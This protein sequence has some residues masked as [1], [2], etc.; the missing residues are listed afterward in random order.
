MKKFLF[1]LFLFF[2]PLNVCANKKENVDL[3]KC[4]DG[5]TSIV[6]D[7][8]NEIKIR[9]LAIDT[10]ETKHPTKGEEKYGK[11]ASE[12]TCN[13]LTNANKIQIEYD[14]NSDKK[15]KYDRYLVWVYVDDV[16]LQKSLVKNGLAKVAYLYGD[17]KY[18]DELKELEKE[19]KNA[20]IGIWE[21]YS[22]DNISTLQIILI[23]I[24]AII[25]ISYFLLNK[26][27]RNKTIKN[28]KKK[29]KK[30]IEKN[31]NNLIK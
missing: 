5:D 16:L 10:P 6:N 1:V 8:E 23:I 14:K 2:I 22:E 7:G 9:F 19:A 15:D 24:I 11:E 3:V 29:A 27:Y 12:Y 28:I 20:K 4:V 18:N 31:L 17:Y 25:F 30:E 21:D 13:A 26:K